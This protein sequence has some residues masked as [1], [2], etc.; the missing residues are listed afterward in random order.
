MKYTGEQ[1]LSLY[2]NNTFK[3]RIINSFTETY[4]K[5][6]KYYTPDYLNR[7]PIENGA[8]VY[9]CM[10]EPNTFGYRTLSLLFDK[11]DDHKNHYINGNDDTTI[12]ISWK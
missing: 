5:I 8:K 1:L 6:R 2:R 11:S 3:G 10:S 4:I 9:L 7:D 12:E